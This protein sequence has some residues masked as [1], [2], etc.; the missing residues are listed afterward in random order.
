[1]STRVLELRVA[2]ASGTLVRLALVARRFGGSIRELTV[3]ADPAT[4]TAR[5]RIA[6][7]GDAA[8]TARIAD[9]LAAFADVHAVVR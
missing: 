7:G 6:L 9:R 3:T 4:G 8:T 2:D 5:M 1:M